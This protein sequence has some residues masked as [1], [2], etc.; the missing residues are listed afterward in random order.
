MHAYIYIYM[1][2][3]C[4]FSYLSVPRAPRSPSAASSDR[5]TPCV[6]DCCV[7]VCMYYTIISCYMMSYCTI[8]YYSILYY[9]II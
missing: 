5:R 8:L 1:L 3:I 2:F 4:S 7:Y 9:I 6:V